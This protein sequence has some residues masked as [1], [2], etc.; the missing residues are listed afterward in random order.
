[1]SGHPS[2]DR[3]SG[4]LFGAIRRRRRAIHFRPDG[5]EREALDIDTKTLE[6]RI[7][8]CYTGEPRNS[9]T[10]NWEITKRHI[11]GDLEIFQIFEGIRD[12]PRNLRA[13]LLEKRLDEVGEIMQYRAS[14]PKSF[15]RTSLRRRWIC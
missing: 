2:S 14:A 6:D 4:L 8:V 10:N 15:R 13:A 1:M 3:I 11:D 9:G 12:T 5:I 7:V